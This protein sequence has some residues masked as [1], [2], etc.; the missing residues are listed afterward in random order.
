[1]GDAKT[2]AMSIVQLSFQFHW[3]EPVIEIDK[4]FGERVVSFSEP[5]NARSPSATHF[6]R[7]R[8]AA[9]YPSAILSTVATLPASS[10]GSHRSRENVRRHIAGSPGRNTNRAGRP[11]PPMR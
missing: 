6:I 4:R 1:M 2:S 5:K 9:A 8:P 10:E 11:P 3:L 7:L